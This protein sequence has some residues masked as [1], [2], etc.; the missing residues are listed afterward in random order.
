MALRPSRG[1]RHPH[2]AAFAVVQML[3]D[4]AKFG[5]VVPRACRRRAGRVGERGCEKRL[6]VRC[7][8]WLRRNEVRHRHGVI[9]H[10]GRAAQIAVM[11]LVSGDDGRPQRTSQMK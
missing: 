6:L 11:K 8:T 3:W 4:L 7:C 9:S 1:D 2:T 10:D 5:A